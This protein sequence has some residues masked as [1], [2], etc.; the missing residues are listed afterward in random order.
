LKIFDVE[1]GI[2]SMKNQELM[3]HT[4]T[5]QSVENLGPEGDKSPTLL[6]GLLLVVLAVLMIF[7]VVASRQLLWI[8]T[9]LQNE[10][11]NASVGN[12]ELTEAKALWSEE[13]TTYKVIDE[14]SGV[15][16]IPVDAAV[17]EVVRKYQ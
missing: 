13:L 9:S 7:I 6:L 16:Q 3:G 2:E 15:Y 17:N 12:P 1:A 10:A 5:N 4:D 11:V 8:S 14:S